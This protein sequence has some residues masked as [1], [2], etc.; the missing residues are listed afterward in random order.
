MVA[1][2]CR[3]DASSDLQEEEHHMTQ[4]SEVVVATLNAVEASL[5]PPSMSE[6]A[7]SEV[8]I[9]ETYLP[10][11]PSKL[12][13]HFAPVAGGGDP[14]R[15]LTYYLTSQRNRREYLEGKPP[16]WA[17]IDLRAIRLG[18]QMEK[19]ERFWV[20]AALMGIYH[21]AP[22]RTAAFA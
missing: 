7:E 11:T 20:V 2:P 18:Q 12:L 16:G 15:F 9:D 13:K 19:D 3:L 8:V 14:N 6:P 21:H 17:L 22:D 10:F 5:S 1:A 4:K